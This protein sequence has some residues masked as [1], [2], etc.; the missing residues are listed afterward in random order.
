MDSR[1]AICIV[2]VL[3][4]FFWT[5]ALVDAKCNYVRTCG[6]ECEYAPT[7]VCVASLGYSQSSK[8]SNSSIN[9][10]LPLT[11]YSEI[12]ECGKN[13]TFVTYKTYNDSLYCN[14]T[15]A[16]IEIITRFESVTQQISNSNFL[17]YFVLYNC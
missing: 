1:T 6:N 15:V 9:Y 16:S 4:F 7:D 5:L 10:Q 12:Y 13:S 14:G 3:L 17:L 2:S 8:I 11:K